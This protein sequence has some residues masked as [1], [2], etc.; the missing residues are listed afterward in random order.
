MTLNGRGLPPFSRFFEENRAMVLRFLVV[1]VGAHEAED[2][3]QETFLSA[4]KSYAGLRPD[5]NLRAWVLRIAENKAID[6]LRK[7]AR[8]AATGGFESEAEDVYA[9]G[10][11]WSAVRALPS[12]QLSA[13]ALRFIADLP[14][15]TIAEEMG[16][17]EDAARQN[18]RAALR[19]LRKEVVR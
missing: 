10:D 9:D 8:T 13:V 12:K 4:L 17:T 5:S 3:F 6:A 11:L 2:C 19:N 1:R 16:T 15:R 7:R 18:V 14:Y